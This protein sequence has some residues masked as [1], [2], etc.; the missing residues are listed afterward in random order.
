MVGCGAVKRLD[1]EH[2]ELKSMRTAA[3]RKR[4]GIASLLMEHILIEAKSMGFGRLSLETG[5]TEFFLAGAEVVR[6]V[7]VR[8]LR[9]VR[10]LSA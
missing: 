7:R 3:E 2:A 4:T 5:S 6:A 1:A 9:A 10:G 8:V